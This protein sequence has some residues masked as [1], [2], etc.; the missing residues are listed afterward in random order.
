M[1]TASL[2]P[3]DLASPFMLR[4]VNVAALSLIPT[5]S[6]L[7]GEYFIMLSGKKKKEK[8]SRTEDQQSRS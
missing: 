5:W 2:R 4:L 1:E 3:K 6:T 7:K 8:V